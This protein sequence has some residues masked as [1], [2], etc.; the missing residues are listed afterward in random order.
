MKKLALLGASGHGKV[1]ADIAICGGWQDVVFYD[2]AWPQRQENGA[3]RVVGDTRLLLQHIKDFDGVL[4][5]IGDCATR[6]HKH[7]ELKAIGAPFVTLIHPKAYISSAAR[8]GLGSV[9]MP[10]SI[11]NVDASLGEACIVNTAATI[12]HDCQLGNAVHVSPGA[13]LSGNVAIGNGSWVGLGALIKQG[14][15]IGSGVTIGAGALVLGPV[16]DCKT[17]IGLP[18][19][20]LIKRHK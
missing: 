20:E 19:R 5:S 17:V 4:V 6:W 7:L 2:D 11:I 14:V 10:G 15:V 1:V 16:D 3:W 9:V 12:D 18:A 8:L 13:H